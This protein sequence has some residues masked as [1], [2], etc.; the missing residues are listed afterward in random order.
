MKSIL[1][2]YKHATYIYI[3]YTKQNAEAFRNIN[4]YKKRE[5]FYR[6]LNPYKYPGKKRCSIWI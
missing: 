3:M 4:I 2:S 6:A 5:T 1:Y